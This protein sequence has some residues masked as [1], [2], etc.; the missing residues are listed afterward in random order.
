MRPALALLLLSISALASAPDPFFDRASSVGLTL[1]PAPKA[2]DFIAVEEDKRKPTEVPADLAAARARVGNDAMLARLTPR[3]AGAPFTFGVIGDAEH[4]RFWWERIFSPEKAAFVDQ[5]RALQTAGVDF[6]LQLGDFVSEG[7]AK[8]YRA[9]VKVIEAEAVRPLLRCVGNHDRSRPNGDADKNLYDA[10]FGA[11]DYFFDHGGWRFVSL[12]S[13]DRKV[14][15][16]QLAWLKA[17]LAVPGPK[18]IF[19]HVPPDYIKSIKP[20]A[21]VGELVKETD[22]EKGA[23]SDFFTN[24][25]KDGSKEFEELVTNGGVK[26]V[27]MGHIHAFWA[28]DHR[29]VRYVISGGGGSPLYPLPPGYPK[30]RFAHVLRVVA[31][32]NGLTETVVPYKGT[33]FTLPQVKP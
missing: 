26:A 22:D 2:P 23:I 29:G 31:D 9:H 4:G 10:V 21:E 15:A 16:A 3:T 19:T 6:A 30:K 8:N 28:A 33:P 1:P 24:Y 32:K 13:S 11:R 27:Y 20:L 5:W 25:F 12:D 18:V 7:D 14:T 17:A